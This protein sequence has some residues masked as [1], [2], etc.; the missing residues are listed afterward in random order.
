[1]RSTGN[2]SVGVVVVTWNGLENTRRCVRSLLASSFPSLRICVVDNG[3]HPALQPELQREFP[4]IHVLTLPENLGY[5]GGCNAGLRWAVEQRCC[6][7]LLLNDDTVADPDLVHYLVERANAAPALA[8]VA[9]MIVRL[10]TPDVVWSAGGLIRKPWL[11]ADNIGDG[12]HVSLYATA[13]TVEWATGCALLFPMKVFDRVGPMDERYFLYLEDVEWCLRARR[14]GVEVWYEPRARLSH[15]VSASAVK[16]DTRIV[17]YY[18]YRNYYLLAFGP[19]PLLARL[20]FGAH[21]LVTLAKIGVRSAV[22]PRYRRDGWYHARTRALID[23]ARG[24]FGRAP[25]ADTPVPS[26]EAV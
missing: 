13:R 18:A 5:A 9:P 12:E 3:S 20:W 22:F 1:M 14:R 26:R 25:Y 19:T 23:F 17:R 6:Y 10:Q 7:G 15:E 16:M 24:R 8:I 11:K 21:L 2:G 4:T